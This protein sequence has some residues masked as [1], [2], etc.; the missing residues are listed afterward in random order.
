[1]I[2][3]PSNKVYV[4]SSNRGCYDI[5]IRKYV[6]LGHNVESLILSFIPPGLVAINICVDCAVAL[7][8]SGTELKANKNLVEGHRLLNPASSVY[9]VYIQFQYDINYKHYEEVNYEDNYVDKLVYSDNESEYY[10]YE[11][12]RFSKGRKVYRYKE[13]L[14]EKEIKSKVVLPSIM[15]EEQKAINLFNQAYE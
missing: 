5:D 9:S 7:R 11:H 2:I 6:K 8:F 10:D 15:I 14:E 3:I 1:M 13:K 4:S 12:S